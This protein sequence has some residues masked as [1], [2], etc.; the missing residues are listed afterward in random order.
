MFWAEL[1]GY[2]ADTSGFFIIP[3]ES[4]LRLNLCL[5][6]RRALNLALKE[7][8]AGQKLN[9]IGQGIEQEARRN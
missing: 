8:R 6:T 1:G 9:R 2:V 3:P 5:V 7:A 4:D